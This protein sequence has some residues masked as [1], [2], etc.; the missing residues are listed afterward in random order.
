MN[1]QQP[2]HVRP[3]WFERF[4]LTFFGLIT[5]PH[6]VFRPAWKLD[7]PHC[8]ARELEEWEMSSNSY[9]YENFHRAIRDRS[10]IDSAA[11]INGKWLDIA[12]LSGV[13]LESPSSS[14]LA[15]YGFLE[16]LHSEQLGHVAPT[17]NIVSHW[18]AQGLDV[19]ST[20]MM[21]RTPLHYA[22]KALNVG[23]IRD[24]LNAGADP[25]ATDVYGDTPLHALAKFWSGKQSFEINEAIE[26]LLIH[27]AD[28]DQ[29]NDDGLTFRGMGS[30]E[31]LDRLDRRDRLQEVVAQTRTASVEGSP[32][33]AM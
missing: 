3:S 4:K 19:T 28:L 29:P 5:A 25:L 9:S 23:A 13:S 17:R 32:R 22:V 21:G 2:W 18:Q 10:L 33:R 15:Y 6:L 8:Y 7:L 20:C 14:A 31:V 24:L 11:G 12:D 1:Y 30:F 27:G 16:Q 26:L